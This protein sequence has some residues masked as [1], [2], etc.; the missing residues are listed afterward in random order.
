MK[1]LGNLQKNTQQ[2]KETGADGDDIVVNMSVSDL[3]EDMIE[4]ICALYAIDVLIM[5]HLNMEDKYCKGHVSD[6]YVSTL[7]WGKV[8]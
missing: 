4:E 8:W 5:R 3:S 1:I 7:Y 2:D 6:K